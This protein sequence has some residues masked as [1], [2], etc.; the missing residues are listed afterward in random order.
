MNL[1]AMTAAAAVGVAA[2]GSACSA[3]HENTRPVCSYGAPVV[4]MAQSVPSASLIPCVRSLP[5]GWHFDGMDVGNGG[6]HFWLDS[7]LL[8]ERAL[9]VRLSRGCDTDGARDADGDEPGAELSK[10]SNGEGGRFSEEWFYRFDGGCVTYTFSSSVEDPGAVLDQ[11]EVGV[12]FLP[13]RAIAEGYRSHV[14][15]DLGPSPSPPG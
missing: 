4:L 11:V 3:I 1:R 14:G 15:K 6:S 10:R 2:M 5:A 7:E 9:D 13:R 8:G 12:S